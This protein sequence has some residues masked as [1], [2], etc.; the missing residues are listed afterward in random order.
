MSQN[1]V[2]HTIVVFDC[3]SLDSSGRVQQGH[4]AC[5]GIGRRIDTT[6]E[7]G[8]R[9]GF[10]NEKKENISGEVCKFKEESTLLSSGTA[11]RE[12]H[13]LVQLLAYTQ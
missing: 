2:F 13:I 9:R 5:D 4:G 11:G 3:R 8:G 1:V 12:Q 10:S 6:I 7:T